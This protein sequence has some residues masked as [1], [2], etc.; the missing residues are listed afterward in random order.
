MTQDIQPDS[1]ESRWGIS[2]TDH[3]PILERGSTVRLS[4]EGS[5]D[6]VIEDPISYN[7]H[8]ES[9]QDG[10]PYRQG[11]IIVLY[12]HTPTAGKWTLAEIY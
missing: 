12:G 7:P 2:V 3:R 1:E 8:L 5:R 11:E 10:M 6:I 9:R 4:R